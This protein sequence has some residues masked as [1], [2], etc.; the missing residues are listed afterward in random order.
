[1]HRSGWWRSSSLTRR[2]ERGDSVKRGAELAG[3]LALD[4]AAATAEADVHA[5]AE[6]SAAIAAVDDHS[7]TGVREQQRR[8]EQLLGS[9]ELRRAGLVADVWCTAFVADKRPGATSITQETLVRAHRGEESLSAD[10]LAVVR[11]A[12][13]AYSFLHWHVAFPAVWD[14][15]GFDVVLGNPPW[16]RV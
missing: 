12:R 5:L 14:R 7:L 1:M 8:F 3:Q 6:Q 15:G 2:L 4:I 13:E 16:E 9:P 11:W 10:E